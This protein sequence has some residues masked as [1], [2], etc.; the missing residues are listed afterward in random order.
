M[1][2][3][4][5]YTWCRGNVVFAAHDKRGGFKSSISYMG[6]TT[7]H[8]IYHHGA[9]KWKRMTSKLKNQEKKLKSVK[10]ILHYFEGQQ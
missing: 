7:H 2:S 5:K 8:G 10:K 4:N 6:G 3:I 9:G 1:I